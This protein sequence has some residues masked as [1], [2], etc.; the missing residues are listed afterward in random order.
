MGIRFRW[1][2]PA[3]LLAVALVVP[4][5]AA[6]DK[7][8]SQSTP[9]VAVDAGKVK[10]VGSGDVVAFKGIPYA[11]P[12]VGDLRWREPQPPEH[13][14]GVRECTRFGNACPQ[15]I[16]PVMNSIP[17]MKLNAPMSEDCL[18]LNVWAPA[19]PAGK[20][21]VLVWIHGGGYTQGA[22]SQPLYDGEQLARKG[23]VVV[24]MNYRLGPLGFL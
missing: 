23:A 14:S 15:R 18:Y 17:Q 16:D 21:P 4:L 5:A 10:G 11:K 24:S 9:V 6:E 3:A 20:L 8:A 2:R 19:K 1:S 7:K 22:A 12:P 13:W